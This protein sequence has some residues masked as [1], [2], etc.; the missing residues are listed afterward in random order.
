MIFL[1]WNLGRRT[2][3]GHVD[4]IRDSGADTV[5]LQ[6]ISPPQYAPLARELT[7]LGLIHVDGGPIMRRAF[8][9]T[10]MIASRWPIADV[11]VDGL[12]ILP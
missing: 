3:T 8:P 11:P 7:A 1:T 12:D 5:A 6:E 10:S 4:L 9:A 2:H